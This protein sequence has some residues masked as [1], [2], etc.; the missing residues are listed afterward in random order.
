MAALLPVCEQ[1][2]LTRRFPSQMMSCYGHLSCQKTWLT[3]Q[4]TGGA[5]GSH[6][7]G[8][9]QICK[10]LALRLPLHTSR[11][12]IVP[13]LYEKLLVVEPL[14]PTTLGKAPN[15][16]NHADL[17]VPSAPTLK[18]GR[19]G[20]PHL[21]EPIPELIISTIHFGFGSPDDPLTAT[22]PL[23]AEA[24]LRREGGSYREDRDIRAGGWFSLVLASFS[25]IMKESTPTEGDAACK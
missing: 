10:Q 8:H 7:Y 20:S 6:R 1:L 11:T 24:K 9:R 12:L 25:L 17:P 5:T 19:L 16:R 15:L 3:I 23:G 21:W 18:T 14:C 4:N 22:L 2:V 13:D